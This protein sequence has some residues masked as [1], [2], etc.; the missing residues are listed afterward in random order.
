MDAGILLYNVLP[1]IM[2]V[3]MSYFL[4]KDKHTNTN[5][6]ALLIS[7]S[8]ESAQNSRHESECYI[9]NFS[10]PLYIE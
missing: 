8:P 9:C 10:C 7:H 5:F 2:T 3:S 1:T 6:N 4:F